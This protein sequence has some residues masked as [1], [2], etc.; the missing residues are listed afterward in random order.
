MM[1]KVDYFLVR[2]FVQA[3]NHHG[4]RTDYHPG[5]DL[6]ES[7]HIIH[8]LSSFDYFNGST[9]NQELVMNSLDTVFTSSPSAISL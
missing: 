1:Q 7:A 2:S 4:A 9:T 8:A 3:R 6:S 5:V